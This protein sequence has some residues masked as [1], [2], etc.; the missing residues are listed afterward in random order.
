MFQYYW[1][2]S[3]PREY[4]IPAFLSAYGC[5]NYETCDNGDLEDGMEKIAIYASQGQPAHMARQLENGHWTTKFG[6]LEDVEH[7][8]LECLSGPGYGDVQVYMKRARKVVK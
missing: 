1:P 2:D 5:L 6:N 8:D 7:I 4:T 3:A